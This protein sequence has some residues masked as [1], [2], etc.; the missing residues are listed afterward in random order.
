MSLKFRNNHW[1]QFQKVIPAVLPAVPQTA[2]SF[3]KLKWWL[4]GNA[5]PV[6]N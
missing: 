5:Q 6:T 1:P 4:L 3:H 2:D